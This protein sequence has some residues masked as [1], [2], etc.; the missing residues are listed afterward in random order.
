MFRK[1]KQFL[2][3]MWHPSFYSDYIAFD[4]SWNVKE[5]G[6]W[7][8]DKRNMFMAIEVLYLS[9]CSFSFDHCVVCSSSI[10]RFCF[11]LWYLQTLLTKTGQWAVMYLFVRS[12]DSTTFL[13]D[14]LTKQFLFHMWHPSFYSDYIAF[15]KSWNVKEWGDWD[16]DKRNMFMAICNTDIPKRL[17]KKG[18][19]L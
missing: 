4:K 19:V 12:I 5:W 14:L 18:K 11:P 10:Y 8:Y 17:T 3:H 7:D 9:F 1:G 13:L 2:F 15:D 6:D 16:Y